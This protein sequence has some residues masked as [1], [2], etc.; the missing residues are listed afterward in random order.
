MTIRIY[1]STDTGAPALTGEAGSLLNVLSTCLVEG[2]GD[3]PPAGW[4]K[5]YQ[6]DN[7]GV[8]TPA[9]GKAFYLQVT[10]DGTP[11]PSYS[12]RIA[13]VRIYETMTDATTGSDP[14]PASGI[15]YIG[16]SVYLSDLARPWMLIADGRAFYLINNPQ[17]PNLLD[18]DLRYQQIHFAGQMHAS[19]PADNWAIALSCSTRYYVSIN[20]SALQLAKVV[21][22][23][24]GTTG[25]DVQRSFDGATKAT[26]L[27]HI[28]HLGSTSNILGNVGYTVM[29]N[30]DDWLLYPMPVMHDHSA[31]GIKRAYMPGLWLSVG[32]DASHNEYAHAGKLIDGPN[33]ANTLLAIN[34][35]LSGHHAV[36]FID[37]TDW[38]RG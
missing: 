30:E 34:S 20:N 13:G 1:K 11:H 3:H 25:M 15:R 37:L 14:I 4:S 29:E 22:S 24:S 7:I 17:H 9:S 19:N 12:Y 23:G 31:P 8:Y 28:N 2:Y 6:A 16:K 32:N 18:G 36:F 35:R 10:D 38:G 5:A 27:S 33:G 26:Y 21:P